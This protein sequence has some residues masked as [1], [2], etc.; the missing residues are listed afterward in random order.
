MVLGVQALDICPQIRDEGG[1]NSR[2]QVIRSDF[3]HS[4]VSAPHFFLLF[5]LPRNTHLTQAHPWPFG[6]A[7]GIA[8]SARAIGLLN[9]WDFLLLSLLNSVWTPSPPQLQ[10]PAIQHQPTGDGGAFLFGSRRRGTKVG[11]KELKLGPRITRAG[12][13][14][15]PSLE[16]NG[17]TS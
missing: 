2:S 10:P 15:W 6:K 4:P 11:R 1:N 17:E 14:R 8:I 13:F 7:S 9:P 3:R 12:K 5:P 16:W